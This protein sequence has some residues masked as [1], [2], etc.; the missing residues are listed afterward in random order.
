M[1][2]VSC[3]LLLGGQTMVVESQIVSHIRELMFCIANHFV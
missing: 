1:Y 3:S 2:D